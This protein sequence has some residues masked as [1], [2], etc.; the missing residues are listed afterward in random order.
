M[1][2]K[3]FIKIFSILTA[4]LI[5][6]SCTI[7]F[8]GSK[9]EGD[10]IESMK[11][12]LTRQALQLTQAALSNSSGGHHGDSQSSSSGSQSGSSQSGQQSD[13]QETDTTVE[14]E[15]DEIP[16]ND[17]HIIGETI[18]DGTVFE[19]GETFEKNLDAAQRRGLRLDYKL[20]AEVH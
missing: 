3:R 12:E 10:D 17:S 2:I 14:E 15:E 13:S 4:L 20:Q 5:T 16:C 1:E 18:T 8:A 7:S 19:P 9:D 11:L 6:L